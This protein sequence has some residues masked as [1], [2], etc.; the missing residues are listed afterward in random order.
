[1]YDGFEPDLRRAV[2]DG[3]YARFVHETARQRGG[4]PWEVFEASARQ[5]L[6][7][8]REGGERPRRRR[9]RRGRRRG[10]ALGAT[11]R[12]FW[13][14]GRPR[15]LVG[16]AV[17]ATVRR[18]RSTARRLAR[19]AAKASRRLVTGGRRLGRVAI[20]IVY[21]LWTG[22]QLPGRPSWPL[23]Y[24]LWT[25]RKWKPRPRVKKPVPGR[26]PAPGPALAAYLG[27]STEREATYMVADPAIRDPQSDWMG[28]LEDFRNANRSYM[29]EL[30]KLLQEDVP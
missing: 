4:A 18:T 19:S 21:R 17:K 5:R 13:S 7:W 3:A 1:M 25:G 10:Q 9:R 27:G 2:E 15:S 29:Q 14:P 23:I 8:E 6:A 16:R 22:R 28:A 26:V 30:Q 11:L 20:P 24:Q 12:R